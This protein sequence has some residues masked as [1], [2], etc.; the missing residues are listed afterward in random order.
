MRVGAEGEPCAAGRMRYR[1]YL[2][3]A[4]HECTFDVREDEMQTVRMTSSDG[5][6]EV[7]LPTGRITV[8][9]SVAPLAEYLTLA[10]AVGI[11]FVNMRK[12]SFTPVHS[13]SHIN[14]TSISRR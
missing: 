14:P 11:T 2:V 4:R 6:V 8:D 1:V 10:F 3:G 12:H 13:P 5:S 9:A 7:D